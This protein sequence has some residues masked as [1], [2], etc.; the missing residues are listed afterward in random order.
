M[1]PYMA[2]DVMN[3]DLEERT[4]FWIIWLGPQFPHRY[5]YRRE[6]ERD[7]H[8]EKVMWRGSG[9]QAMWLRAK[10]YWEP[11][12]D[13]PPNRA[14]RESA[15]LQTP[16]FGFLAFTTLSEYV[17]VVLS[18]LVWGHFVMAA[19]CACSVASVMSD[20][21]QP[22]GLLPTRLLCPWDS[23]S[24][25]TGVCCHALLQRIFPTRDQTRVSY[26]SCIGRQVLY[27]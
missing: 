25:N 3:C 2:I 20:S 21:L 24:K 7:R 15:A 26:V 27:H 1:L 4:L 17:S 14:S 9:V 10:A 18:H 13:H 12:T 6:A 22:Y 19:L 16:C 11:E 8:A 23:P 5:P